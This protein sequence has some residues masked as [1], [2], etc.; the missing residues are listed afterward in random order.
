M[1]NCSRRS[2]KSSTRSP[3]PADTSDAA[4]A[5][6]SRRWDSSAQR[7]L[8]DGDLIVVIIVV[9][10]VIIVFVV[11]IVIIVEIIIEVVVI[12]VIVAE[13]SLGVFLIVEELKRSDLLERTVE[14]VL[15]DVESLG[16]GH[17][18]GFDSRVLIGG[19]VGRCSVVLADCRKEL[20]QGHIG[21][22]AHASNVPPFCRP[23][24]QFEPMTRGI[25]CHR[26]RTMAAPIFEHSS[27]DRFIAGTVGL[28]GERTF[29][30]QAASEGVVTSVTLEKE[31]VEMLGERMDELLDMV[32]A[33]G[34]ST[35]PIPVGP[36]EELI[37]NAGLAMPVD[38][39]FI[40][41]TMSLGWD[42]QTGLL[43]VECFELT[44]QDAESGTSGDPD[45]DTQERRSLKVTLTAGQAREFARRADQVVNAGRSD[46]PFCALPLDP[47]GHMC[48]RANGI[49]R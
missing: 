41:G 4:A 29:F 6:V 32:R 44:Q 14:G 47:A 10:V 13:V 34:A 17:V 11:V 7:S 9:E 31:Q 45:D 28:P 16:Q 35:V 38:A 3:N 23:R 36:L 42:T 21:F 19:T 27:P 30:L 8:P 26:V 12:I 43:I 48:P 18:G 46:C 49:A 5:A 1:P 40:V 22:K 37:D 33:K 39:E 2:S 25:E 20:F 24:H 15:V